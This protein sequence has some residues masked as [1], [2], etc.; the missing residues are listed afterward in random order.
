MKSNNNSNNNSNINNNNSNI[1]QKP[2]F[3]PYFSHYILVKYL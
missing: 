2:T 1:K 3:D